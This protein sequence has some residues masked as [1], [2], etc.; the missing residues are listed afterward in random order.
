MMKTTKPD[1]IS[2]VVFFSFRFNAIM[3]NSMQYLLYWLQKV[4]CGP[5]IDS[6]DTKRKHELFV[7]FGAGR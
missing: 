4:S 3:Q 2:I 7:Y 5:F 1:E 6:T